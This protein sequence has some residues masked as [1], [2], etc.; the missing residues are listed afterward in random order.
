MIGSK[1]EHSEGPSISD[2]NRQNADSRQH[3]AASFMYGHKLYSRSRFSSI[4]PSSQ[5]YL[6]ESSARRLAT[7]SLKTYSMMI[8]RMNL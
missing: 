5:R 4:D 3:T 7:A 1:S 6:W 2:R 8:T